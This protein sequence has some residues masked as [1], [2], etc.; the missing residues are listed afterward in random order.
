MSNINK[1]ATCLWYESRAE[2]AAIFYTSLI[3]DSSITGKFYPSPEGIP[4]VVEFTLAGVPYQALNGGPHFQLT[5]AASIVVMTEDQTETDHLWYALIAD[6]G[7]ESMC[8]WLKDR[9]GLSWQVVPRRFVELTTSADKAAAGR[10]RDAVMKMNK[11][12]VAVLEAAYR[13]DSKDA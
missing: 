12:E 2:E 9:F 10:V 11:L 8:G 7:N 13:G 1:I 3:A 4:L 6:G 5:E